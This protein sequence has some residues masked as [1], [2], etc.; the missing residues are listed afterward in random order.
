LGSLVKQGDLIGFVGN[1]GLSTGPHLHYEFRI[2]GTHINPLEIA[3]P[4]A[5]S[6]NKNQVS[7]FKTAT[8][9]YFSSLNLLRQ[10]QI[11]QYN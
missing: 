10:F 8:S 1:T 2:K 9:N 6:L 4:D 3:S 5:K 11:A 7:E